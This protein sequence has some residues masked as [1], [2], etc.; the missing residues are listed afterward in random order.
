M[1]VMIGGVDL[2]EDVEFLVEGEGSCMR[3]SSKKYATRSVKTAV[4]QASVKGFG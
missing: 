1:V 2:E 4:P 3:I